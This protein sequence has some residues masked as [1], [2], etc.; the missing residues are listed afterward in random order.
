MEEKIVVGLDIGTTK[1][2]CFIG[3]RGSR[4]DKIKI[5]GFG[6][7]DSNGVRSGVVENLQNTA[8]SIKKAVQAAEDQA[9]I[10]VSE[11]YI[12]VAGYHIQT[13]SMEASIPVPQNEFQ[14]VSQSD[15]DTLT[16]TLRDTATTEEGED[17]IHIFPQTYSVDGRKLANDI[18]PVGVSGHV[19]KGTFNVIIGKRNEIKKLVD[20]VRMA[21]Y[22]VAGIVLEP[23]A[24]SYAVLNENDIADGVALVDIGGGTT[25]IAVLYDNM[26]RYT[27]VIS[28]AGD[29]I[30]TDISSN[31]GIVRQKAEV[32]K[33]RFGECLPSEVNPNTVVSIPYNYGQPAREI[34][35]RTLAEI[36]KNRVEIILGLVSMELDNSQMM[37]RIRNNGIALTGGGANMKNI[38]E[39]A[40][41]VTGVHCH[42]GTPGVHLEPA[43]NTDVQVQNMNTYNDTMYAT[44]I[45]LVI[46]GLNCEEEKEAAKE[47][48]QTTEE[49]NI[50]EDTPKEDTPIEDTPVEPVSPI[51]NDIPEEEKP[52]EP[53][54]TEKPKNKKKRF[55]GLLDPVNDWLTKT[56]F[57]GNDDD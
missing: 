29:S 50:V 49:E 21:G 45:G 8:E 23:V 13:K 6:R 28:M 42:I 14:I 25:D 16:Q 11:V 57:E 35:Q 55:R 19:L 41:L 7:S 40:M 18:P 2:A 46:Y 5:L 34:S 10:A 4:R 53:A 17:I 26:V 30:T 47:E 20:T 32:L 1:I 52:V 48:A 36:I 9:G 51:I 12:G 24:S 22:S 37:T 56:L 33:K 54:I 44:G 3:K 31:C 39:L 43:D 27:L 38:Q 15:I